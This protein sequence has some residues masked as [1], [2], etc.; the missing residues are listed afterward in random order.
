MQSDFGWLGAGRE[1]V[2]FVSASV[3][4]A[5]TL[6]AL[7]GT[8]SWTVVNVPDLSGALA[9]LEKRRLKLVVFDVDID[10]PGSWR[11]LPKVQE[12]F[13]SFALVV[14]SRHADDTLWAEVLASGGFDLL[15]KPFIAEGVHHVM[16]SVAR[17]SR[18][19]RVALA[20]KQVLSRARWNVSPPSRLHGRYESIPVCMPR[21]GDS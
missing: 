3:E 5:R 14:A 10:G 19:E 11:D 18:Q 4:D 9:V 17:A 2:L 8:A 13:L 7:L 16:K 20:Y 1:L 12:G 15:Q 21:A 6:Q